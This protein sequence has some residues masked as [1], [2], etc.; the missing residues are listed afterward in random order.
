MIRTTHMAQAAYS[1]TSL[2][3][4]AY[5]MRHERDALIRAIDSGE[6][7]PVADPK[8]GLI[9]GLATSDHVDKLTDDKSDQANDVLSELESLRQELDTLE[10]IVKEVMSEKLPADFDY[11]IFDCI[12]DAV[13]ILNRAQIGAE[14]L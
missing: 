11:R 14:G 3:T 6:L 8:E 12:D 5:L 4:M 2:S 7:I 10:T 1:N 9:I 13:N